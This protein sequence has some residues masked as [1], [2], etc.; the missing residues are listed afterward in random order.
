MQK[1]RRR[2]FLATY[3]HQTATHFHTHNPNHFITPMICVAGAVADHLLATM[4]EGRTLDKAYINNGGDIA[5]YLAAGQSLDVG[6]CA[7]PLNGSLASKAEITVDSGIGG[8][9]TSGWRGR[10]HSLGIADAVT[11]LAKD[12]ATADTAATLIANATD[13][14]GHAAIQREPAC[15]LQ[16][17]SDLGERLV[18]TAVAELSMDEIEQALEPGQKL[19]QQM[20]DRSDVVAVYGSLQSGSFSVPFDCAQGTGPLV[21]LHQHSAACIERSRNEHSRSPLI[22]KEA[23]HA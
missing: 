3:M 13:L 19:A 21:A 9:A 12:A 11:V 18:T 5:L 14:P 4:L 6:V 23:I 8:I 22:V 20:I 1:G 7:N 16:P 2:G 10:S 17:D 15:E